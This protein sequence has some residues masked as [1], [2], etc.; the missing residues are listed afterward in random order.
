MDLISVSVTGWRRFSSSTTLQ[1]NGKLISILGPNEA[2]KSSLLHAIKALR[3]NEDVDFRDVSRNGDPSALKI[4][5][6]FYLNGQELEDAHLFRPT[7]LVLSKLNTGPPTFNL[8][9][10]PPLRDL[11]PRISAKEQLDRALENAKFRILVGNELAVELHDISTILASKEETLIDDNIEYIIRT[12]TTL[13]EMSFEKLP[14]YARTLSNTLSLLSDIEKAKTPNDYA[15]DVLDGMIPSV[16]LFGDD[17]R[18][19]RQEYDLDELRSDVPPALSNLASVARLDISKLISAID[20]GDAAAIETIKAKSNRIL[21]DRFNEVWSQSGVHASISIKDNTLNVLI[22]NTNDEFTSLAERSDGFRQFVALQ[23][24]IMKDRSSKPILLI[25]EAEIHLH[26]DAQA[27]LVQMLSK[28]QVASKI[29]YTTHSAGCLPEDLGNGVRLVHQIDGNKSDSRVINRFW[30]D[31]D[32]GFSPLLIGMGASTLAFYPT[33]RALVVEGETEMLILPTM[34]RE[35]M[36]LPALGYQVI[37][38]LSRTT[39]SQFLGQKDNVRHVAYLVDGDKGGASLRRELLKY[40]V[41]EKLIFDL[42]YP[43]LQGCEIEDFISTDILAR[44]TNQLI[45]KYYPGSKPVEGRNVATFKKFSEFS[46]RFKLSTKRDMRKVDLAYEILAIVN[47]NPD[48]SIL[49]K[50]KRAFFAKLARD[51][52]AYFFGSV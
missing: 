8:E 36:N 23:S 3:S 17:E 12:K 48:A 30:G 18:S 22:V 51:I 46:S 39:K 27:D 24:F 44:S 43:G 25:D 10:R 14:L 45:G 26:Y 28:Q 49:D 16:L 42:A 34:F 47:E 6:Y 38:G 20:R 11:S 2:G 13:S 40:G 35:V 15:C 31:K 41:S 7:R 37:P 5:G 29:I 33:R 9:P 50:S 1:T 32:S 4:I 21:R 52:D 19:L